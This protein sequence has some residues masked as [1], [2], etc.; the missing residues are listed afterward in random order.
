MIY[1]RALT[2]FIAVTVISSS[3]LSP[4]MATAQTGPAM[5][6][7]MPEPQVFQRMESVLGS[8]RMQGLVS[9]L[10]GVDGARQRRVTNAQ[11]ARQLRAELVGEPPGRIANAGSKIGH[12]ARNFATFHVASTLTMLMVLA[13]IHAVEQNYHNAKLK[14]E[15]FDLTEN[16][17]AAFLMATGNFQVL[18]AIGGSAIAS[19]VS[20]KVG[21]IAIKRLQ[22]PTQV[23]ARALKSSTIKNMLQKAAVKGAASLIAF[24]GWEVLGGLFRT[25]TDIIDEPFQGIAKG[26]NFWKI[27]S[28]S[29]TQLENA[30]FTQTM[31]NMW[32][33]LAVDPD[34]RWHW[35]DSV[36]RLSVGTGEFFAILL[37]MIAAGEM[38]SAILPGP[39]TKTGAFG[40]AVLSGVIGGLAAELVVPKVAK[41][42]VTDGIKDLRYANASGNMAST[43]K[44]IRFLFRYVRNGQT[45]QPIVDQIR[46]ILVERT[47][48]RDT[49]M[50]VIFERLYRLYDAKKS[51]QGDMKVIEMSQG[52]DSAAYKEYE[53]KT[54]ETRY[55]IDKSL[56]L[57]ANAA[58]NLIAKDETEIMALYEFKDIDLPT[59]IRSQFAKYMNDTTV[60]KAFLFKMFSTLS[61]HQMESA[62]LRVNGFTLIDME[63]A[64]NGLNSMGFDD[65]AVRDFFA[66]QEK[67]AKD[68]STP[69][70]E[71]EDEP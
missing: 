65:D 66:Q 1:R 51:I 40:I 28:G 20:G 41:D 12:E 64:L 56:W 57:A 35:L 10:A 48:F 30:L 44:T 68:D 29:G 58:M 36:F 59:S 25:A 27:L 15:P 4:V 34:L 39:Q 17:T 47:K 14:N 54:Q 18:F 8:H 13:I 24:L 7:F 23:V 21:A 2:F 33:I 22:D 53:R 6:T 42:F 46:E 38:V 70:I 45:T 43:L 16:L 26:M 19:T 63:T 3:V 31:Q 62:G 60:P 37:S 69:D 49:A 32:L 50:T 11:L 71:S 9:R 61:P 52:L 67:P 55:K 5:W